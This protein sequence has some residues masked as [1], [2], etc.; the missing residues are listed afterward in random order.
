M[1]D[2]RSA[3]IAC[4]TDGIDSIWTISRM[5]DAMLWG[6]WKRC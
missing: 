3:L 4:L 1:E 6:Q 5:I 2:G